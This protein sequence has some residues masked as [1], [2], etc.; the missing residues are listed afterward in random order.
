MHYC[1]D[2]AKMID[3]PILHV[4]GDHPEVREEKG[5]E[6]RGGGKRRRSWP[7]FGSSSQDV[8][9]ATAIALDYWQHFRND[10]IVDMT[11]FRRW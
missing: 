8:V 6:G 4:N 3:S 5:E 2:V 10:V 7:Y 9:R 1:S 11:C